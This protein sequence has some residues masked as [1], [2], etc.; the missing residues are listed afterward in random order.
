MPK[1][2]AALDDFIDECLI[3]DDSICIYKGRSHEL[4]TVLQSLIQ[5]DEKDWEAFEDLAA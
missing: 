2:N 1:I 3:E 4:D 5:M